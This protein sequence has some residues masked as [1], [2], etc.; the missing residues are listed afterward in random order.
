MKKIKKIIAVA[1]IGIMAVTTVGCSMIQKTPEAIRKTVVAKVGKEEI[2]Y[3]QL[4][5]E[6]DYVKEQL[7]SQYG[8]GY[9]NNST[10]VS[11]LNK[12][13]ESLLDSMVLEKV[14][15]QKAEELNIISDEDKFDKEV[16]SQY[17]NIKSS[18]GSDDAFQNALTESKLTEDKL[19]ESVKNSLIA[20]EVEN[21]IIKDVKVEDS[22]VEDYYNANKDSKYTKGAGAN[23][24]HILV[25][26]EA[27]AKTIKDKLD[28]GE[29]FSKLAAEYGT[30]GTKSTGGSLGFVEYDAQNMDKDFMDAAKTLKEGEISGPVKTQFGYHI[31][32]ATGITTEK[33]VQTLDEVKDE[34][35]KTLLQNKQNETYKTTIDEWK[36]ELNVSIDEKAR[37]QEN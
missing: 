26:D 28:A 35:K 8:E 18:F 1:I 10:A 36:K 21:Y 4:D 34:I 19:R 14:Y 9:E 17:D 32:K 11:T 13:R 27:T 5:D 24:Y 7:K 16:Q 20:K 6:L 23:L 22:E 30:D 29:D 15:L 3:G 33:K 37:D 31:I 25:A 2:T 12:Q